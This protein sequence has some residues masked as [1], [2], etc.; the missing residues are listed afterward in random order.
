MK[1]TDSIFPVIVTAGE[2]QQIESGSTH[3]QALRMQI[4]KAKK[5]IGRRRT[6]K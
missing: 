3:P 5:M 2:L 4:E 6:N 1:K